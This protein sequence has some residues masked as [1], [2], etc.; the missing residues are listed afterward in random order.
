MVIFFFFLFPATLSQDLFIN[1][2][3]AQC[4]W[5]LERF[6]TFFPPNFLLIRIFQCLK[7]MSWLP[8]LQTSSLVCCE[9]V[10]VWAERWSCIRRRQR[11]EIEQSSEHDTAGGWTSWL[12]AIHCFS[13]PSGAL[14]HGNSSPLALPLHIITEPLP[15]ALVRDQF[16][17]ASALQNS[18]IASLLKLI[19]GQRPEPSVTIDPVPEGLTFSNSPL[20]VMMWLAHL[21]RSLYHTNATVMRLVW[22]V[23]LDLNSYCVNKGFDQKIDM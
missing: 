8:Q 14:H 2:N 15:R 21:G 16:T 6:G 13:N 3:F 23:M 22:L 19:W 11:E 7:A 17:R 12:P 1:Q 9:E 4:F 10:S 20:G 18:H 5:K